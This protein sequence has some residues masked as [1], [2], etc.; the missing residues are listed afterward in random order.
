[1]CLRKSVEYFLSELWYSS[2]AVA[3]SEPQLDMALENSFC[4]RRLCRTSKECES[5]SIVAT[6]YHSHRA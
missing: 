2:V 4:S 5:V 1:M 3:S 6:C